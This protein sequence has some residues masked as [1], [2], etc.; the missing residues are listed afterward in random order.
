MS[1]SAPRQSRFPAVAG[2]ITI[3]VGIVFVIAGGVTWGL[4]S[5]Q[6]AA[7]EITVSDDAQWF[8]GQQVRGP[9]TAYS[10]ADIINHHALAATGD[11]TYA[12]LGDEMAQLRE[13]G[14][15]EDDPEMQDL[16]A[17][18][19][20][21]MNASFLRASLFTSVVAFGVAALVIGLGVVIGL[22]GFALRSM[23]HTATAPAAPAPQSTPAPATGGSA[24]ASRRP[25]ADTDAD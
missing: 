24:S 17:A 13:D 22:I 18:R 20:T 7:E 19:T 4:V 16:S 5:S 12:E 3:I 21:I 1:T 10:Q 15:A 8:A 14:V 9:L 11:R 25:E 23:A 6:L 2:L